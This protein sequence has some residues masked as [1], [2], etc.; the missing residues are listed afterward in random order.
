MDSNKI[1]FAG[2]APTKAEAMAFKRLAE[3][4]ASSHQQKIALMYLVNVLSRPHDF[5]FVPGSV[6]E[7]A[8]LAGRAF[9]GQK[10]LKM[11]KVPIGKLVLTEV[12]NNNNEAEKD[13]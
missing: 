11:V 9:V 10:L 6:E 5:T 7:S 13:E 12:E 8:F 3:G 2:R 4:E 1:C